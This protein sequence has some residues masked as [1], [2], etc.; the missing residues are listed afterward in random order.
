M[1]LRLEATVIHYQEWR[2]KAY[3]ALFTFSH[4]VLNMSSN[5]VLINVHFKTGAKKTL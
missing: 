3:M 1:P 5:I 2:V 4:Q